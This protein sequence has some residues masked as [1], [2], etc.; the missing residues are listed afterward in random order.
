MKPRKGLFII[1]CA[2]L[3]TLSLDPGWGSC[4]PCIRCEDLAVMDFGPNVTITSATVVPAADG[5]PE[6]CLVTG[7]VLPENNFIVKLPTVWNGNYFQAG[8]GGLAGSIQENRIDYGLALGYA[9]AGANG[10]HDGSITDATFCY[11][12]LDNANPDAEG[13]L[14]DYCFG[15]VHKMNFLGKKIV[16]AYYCREAEYDYYQGCSTGGRQGMIESQR[17]PDDFDGIMAGAPLV[18]LTKITMRDVWQA[19]RA[20]DAWLSPEKLALLAEAVIKKCDSID[21]L[22]D[23]V[24]DDPRKCDF[25]ALSD[26]TACENGYDPC[27]TAAESTAIQK[28]YDGPRNSAGDLL[29]RGAPFGSEAVAA[30]FGPSNSGWMGYIMP[31]APGNLSFGA[32]MGSRFVQYCG[33]PPDGGG[34]GWDPFTFDWDTDWPYVTEK[35]SARCDANNPNLWPFKKRGGKIIQY[36]GWADPLVSPFPMMDYYES[37]LDFMGEKKTKEFYK[38]YMIPGQFHCRGGLGCADDEALFEA[39]VDWV[40][41]KVEPKEIIG[42]RAADPVAGYTARTRPLC[43]Y[44]EV[45]RYFDEGS[46]DNAKNFTCVTLIPAKVQ[47]P[48]RLN[49]RRDESFEAF[50]TLPK[51][52]YRG[53]SW[54]TLAV[55]CEGATAKKITKRKLKIY[56]FFKKSNT[57]MAEF[58]TRD[59]INIT[60][61]EQVT[62]TVTAIFEHHGRRVAFE[63]SDTVIVLE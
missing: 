59:L 29:F 30:H 23:G 25:N 57:Y 48:E 13:K 26:L 35:L 62:F 49:L 16:K 21:G 8:N 43:P 12:P 34:P 60:A 7:T 27:F 58:N 15:S 63:G 37:V 32:M 6:H 46:I 14:D 31:F 54:E 50:I 51:S 10:G 39:L 2:I 45:A 61:G 33:L 18:Y 42:S 22:V 19:H 11:N 40:E 4:D 41:N 1:A 9:A 17:F 5:W 28:I 38:L 36:H 20:A 52:Y 53:R 3:V 55:V 24:I 47:M 44:P 56:N